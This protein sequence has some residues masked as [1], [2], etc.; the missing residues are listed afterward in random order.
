[1]HEVE[2]VPSQQRNSAVAILS[3]FFGERIHI[4]N[5]YQQHNQKI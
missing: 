2:W 1:M 4:K 3:A 5:L